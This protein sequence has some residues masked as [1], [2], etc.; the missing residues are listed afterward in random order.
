MEED[1]RY[2]ALP[3]VQDLLSVV[4]NLQRAIE[5]AAKSP[6]STG[7]LEGVK[8]ISAQFEGGA[9]ESSLPAD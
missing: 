1:R 9:E 5:A 4:D 8:M 7:L 3:I 6:D 2:A